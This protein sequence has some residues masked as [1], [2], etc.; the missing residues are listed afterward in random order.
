MDKNFI[1]TVHGRIVVPKIY[2][3]KIIDTALFQ[4]LRRIEQTSVLRSLFTC[5]HHDRFVHSIGV[6]HI[7]TRIFANL[8]KNT[9]ETISDVIKNV[10]IPYVEKKGWDLLKVTYEVACLLHDCGHSPFSH[11]FEHYYLKVSADGSLIIN[12]D[13][14]TEVEDYLSETSLLKSEKISFLEEFENDFN[15]CSPKPHE[16]VG[17]W[18]VLNKNAFRK[19]I[20][21]DLNID[22]I[23]VARM[24]MGI[25]YT[26]PE[27]S[28]DKQIYNCFI[29]ML[30]GHLI[31]ADRLDYALRDKWATGLNT[32]SINID[33]L[34]STIHINELSNEFIICFKKNALPEL[35]GLLDVKNYTNFW[36]F[37]HHKVLFQGKLIEKAVARLAILLF[38]SNEIDTIFGKDKTIQNYD[39][40]ESSKNEK[41]ALQNFFNY[42]NLIEPIKI[43]TLNVNNI[44][45]H[46]ELYLLSDD[47]IVHLLKKYFCT[48]IFNDIKSTKLNSICVP[49]Y[50]EEWF[51]R[52]QSLIPLWK[53][54]SEYKVKY[55][56]KLLD[57]K[58]LI[59]ITDLIK[60][61]KIKNISE[62]KKHIKS[63]ST[64]NNL[65][66]EINISG[67]KSSIDIIMSNTHGIKNDFIK[68]ENKFNECRNYYTIHPPILEFR[69]AAQTVLR[70]INN[71]SF[72]VDVNSIK[73]IQPKKSIKIDGIN[74]GTVY[75]NIDNNI[76]CYTTLDL[77]SKNEEKSYQFFYIFVPKIFKNNL[78]LENKE[79]YKKFYTD[80]LIEEIKKIR[81]KYE[82]LSSFK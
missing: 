55:F 71:E 20:I 42:R 77:P 24:I 72:I 49:N 14:L 32:V 48:N 81:P 69:E 8:R 4:R 36:I 40:L 30:N 58:S 51:S 15:K 41:A 73:I 29:S 31:D 80:K 57:L 3:E 34:L 70:A 47:D 78:L 61:K 66:S 28:K 79:V 44:E 63:D 17:A 43:P 1:D 82:S 50:A 23:L 27:L 68:I 62:L 12:Q 74:P 16:R 54:Y 67:I 18:L 75:I 6:F 59:L 38:S 21:K 11:T 39:Y 7:G 45:Y 13:I 19:T 25:K 2:C 37:N 33:H 76:V 64:I 26:C 10:S 35:Q 65:I 52:S 53:S 60:N 56:D 22:P 9:H 46:E 5:A